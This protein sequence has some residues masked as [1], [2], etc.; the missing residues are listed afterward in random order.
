VPVVLTGTVTGAARISGLAG[1]DAL[2]ATVT[3][4]ARV[5]GA[6]VG[7]AVALAAVLAAVALA[8]VGATGV[9]A[10]AL[11]RARVRPTSSLR[12]A[13]T[14]VRS[15]GALGLTGSCIGRCDVGNHVAVAAVALAG[16]GGPRST[17][18]IAAV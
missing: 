10:G 18:R 8:V 3:R 7:R 16:I 9:L 4:R 17:V 6:V 11:A 15:A 14:R 12:L 5:P 1:A 2:G 13:A